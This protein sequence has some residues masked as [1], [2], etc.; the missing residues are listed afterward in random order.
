MTIGVL[1]ALRDAFEQ[2]VVAAVDRHSDLVVVRR[3]ADSAE[4]VAAALAGLGTVAVLDAELGIDRSLIARLAAAGAAAVVVGAPGDVERLRSVGAVALPRTAEPGQ[5][6]TAVRRAADDA[7][8]VEAAAPEV[9]EVLPSPERGGL[10]AVWGPHGSPGRTSVAVTLA[11]ELAA[12]GHPTLLI[13]ADVWGAAIAPSLGL[14]EESAG[15]AAALRAA[16]HGTLDAGSLTRVTAKISERLRVLPG[17]PRASRWR[18][19]STPSIDAVWEAARAMAR[20]VVVDTPVWVPEEEMAGFDAVLGPRRNAVGVSALAAADVLVVVGAAEP[21][22]IQRL[23]QALLDLED[24]GDRLPPIRHV[25]VTRVRASAA[26]PR[27]EASV[28]EALARFAGV[29]RPVLIPDDRTALDKATL[30]GATLTE[31][32]PKS[33]ARTAVAALARTIAAP[34]TDRTRGRGRRATRGR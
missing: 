1:V 26:G 14:L 25:A 24:R 31:I 18:E 28:A 3:C 15:L 8:E 21:I 20:W 10:I 7:P 34:V 4:V 22:G 23:V 27:P 12:S 6:V 29:E 9:Q 17:L 16:E 5:V 19:V 11:A 2:E 30:A 32:A 13:D 33:P